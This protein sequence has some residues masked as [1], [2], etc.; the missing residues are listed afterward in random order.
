MLPRPTYQQRSTHPPPKFK[1]SRKSFQQDIAIS[2]C[3]AHLL[4]HGTAEECD[5]LM[6]NSRSRLERSGVSDATTGA[7]AVS[8]IRTSSGMV[9]GRAGGRAGNDGAR[10]QC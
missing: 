10:F 4:A 6:D 9:G 3:Y 7:G 2:Y 8:D 5:Q 1:D